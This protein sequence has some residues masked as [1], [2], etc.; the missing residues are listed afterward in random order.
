MFAEGRDSVVQSGFGRSDWNIEDGGGFFDGEVVLVAE[1]EDGSTGGRD[2]VEEGQEGFVGKFSQVGVECG[3]IFRC[4][5][6]EGLPTASALEVREGNAGGNPVG[7][8]TKDGGLAQERKL[9][10][11]L[12]RGLLKDVVGEGGADE[13]GGLA[14]PKR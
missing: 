3:E 5:G 7:P 11:D 14:T 6:V 10:E 12:E 1:K 9:P 2:E 4:G 13:T 8:W